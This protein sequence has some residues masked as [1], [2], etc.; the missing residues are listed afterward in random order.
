MCAVTQTSNFRDREKT[1]VVFPPLLAHACSV[2][3]LGEGEGYVLY[4]LIA[5]RLLS[6]QARALWGGFASPENDLL[7]LSR[8][9]CRNLNL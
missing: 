2:R 5:G 8:V 9:C 3:S 6:K 1:V 7:K 4:I